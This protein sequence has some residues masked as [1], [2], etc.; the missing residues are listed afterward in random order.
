MPRV[1]TVKPVFLDS[2]THFVSFSGICYPDARARGT[3][4]GA[5]DRDEDHLELIIFMSTWMGTGGG[6]RLVRTDGHVRNESRGSK[7][8]Q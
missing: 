5:T 3:P 2:W 6:V 1:W 7:E 8:A 4:S